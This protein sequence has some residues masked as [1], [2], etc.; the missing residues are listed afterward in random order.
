MHIQ[1]TTTCNLNTKQPR[2]MHK[3]V[4]LEIDHETMT[5][6]NKLA[7]EQGITISELINESLQEE[8]DALEPINA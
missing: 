5:K 7:A 1:V 6:L 3:K 4:P 8:L 2:P